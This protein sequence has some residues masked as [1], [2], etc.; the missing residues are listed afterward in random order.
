[1][2]SIDLTLLSHQRK[3]A[4]KVAGALIRAAR[5]AQ[6]LGAQVVLTGLRPEVAQT[7]VGN[8]IELQGIVTRNDLQSGIAFAT[9]YR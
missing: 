4:C 6:L 9:H 8:G 3:K 2:L 5:A 1:L 7:L